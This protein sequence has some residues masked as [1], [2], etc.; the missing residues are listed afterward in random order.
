MKRRTNRGAAAA[1]VLAVLGAC[2]VASPAKAYRPFDGTDADVAALG[3]FELEAGAHYT[4]SEGT[5]LALPATVLN[6]GI[7][8]EV[9]AVVDFAP[10]VSFDAPPGAAPFGVFGTDF[11]LKWVFRRGS[12]QG[13]PGPSL[14]LETGPLLPEL[15][16]DARFGYQAS[17]LGSERGRALAVHLNAL[18]ALSRL[19][20]P[21]AGGSLILEGIPASA[22]RPVTELFASAT[23][24]E[25]T[26]ISVLAG[27]VW[28]LGG[29]LALDGAGRVGRDDHRSFA[30]VRLG[31]TFAFP[32]WIPGHP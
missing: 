25:G 9:E 4:R 21:S 6:L 24:G 28:T 2:L 14:A 15:H 11:F 31:V 13:E 26:V 16:G 17:V 5:T 1:F 8:P 29:S 30:E 3:E 10:V 7:L 23:R 18:A 19:G 27:A 22:L 32:V 20:H 12:L